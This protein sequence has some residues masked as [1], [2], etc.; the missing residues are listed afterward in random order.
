M[1]LNNQVKYWNLKSTK[2]FYWFSLGNRISVIH[3]SKYK[4]ATE[5][6]LSAKAV[7][8]GNSVYIFNNVLTLGYIS[9]G[10][11]I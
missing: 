8:T 6:L 7:V 2:E 4:Y 11:Q 9:P 10:Q 5:K 1:I 3:D